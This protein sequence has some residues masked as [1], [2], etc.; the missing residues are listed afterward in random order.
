[1]PGPGPRRVG[2]VIRL[3][4]SADSGSP[5][6]DGGG[7]GGGVVLD[8]DGVDQLCALQA[9]V[10]IAAVVGVGRGGKSTLV[11]A[12]AIVAAVE[13]SA[14]AGMHVASDE[15][16]LGA[17]PR[18]MCEVTDDVRSCTRGLWALPVACDDGG[19]LLLIDTEGLDR[20]GVEHEAAGASGA[21]IQMVAL[22]YA[23]SGVVAINVRGAP[24]HSHV[25]QFASMFALCRAVSR[26]AHDRPS[27][28]VVVR[29]CDAEGI[30]GAKLVDRLLGRS[31]MRKL[32]AALRAE[33]DQLDGSFTGWRGC[34]VRSPTE[35]DREALAERRTQ[36]HW[37]AC[38]AR[39]RGVGDGESEAAGTEASSSTG[40]AG[41][42]AGADDDAPPAFWRMLVR[43][44]RTTMQTALATPARAGALQLAGSELAATVRRVWRAIVDFTRAHGL[45]GAPADGAGGAV[46]SVA[47][48]YELLH[49]SRAQEILS[50]MRVVPR[51][52]DAMRTACDLVSTATMPPTSAAAFAARSASEVSA[53][54][55]AVTEA[56]AAEAAYVRGE[57]VRAC[58]CAGV[59]GAAA[60]HAW[61]HNVQWRVDADARTSADFFARLHARKVQSEADEEAA[62]VFRGLAAAKR[63][64]AIASERAARLTEHA[65]NAS[66]AAEQQ[67][68]RAARGD[69]RY[70]FYDPSADAQQAEVRRIADEY[71]AR[72]TSAVGA[73]LDARAR[74]DVERA[75]AGMRAVVCEYDW[76][77]GHAVCGSAML[78]AP[79]TR[80]VREAPLPARCRVG[81]VG[82]EA[83][84]AARVVRA[85]QVAA[86]CK[87]AGS[88]SG[89]GA[90]AGAGG[91]GTVCDGIVL[92]LLPGMGGGALDAG[93]GLEVARAAGLRDRKAAG[94]S[95]DADVCRGMIFVVP[96]VDALKLLQASA[97]D[98]RRGLL[99]AALRPLQELM[100]RRFD[101]GGVVA[102]TGIEGLGD[103]RDD[104]LL[105][106]LS[107]VY[108]CRRDRVFGVRNAALCDAEAGRL[109][110]ADALVLLSMLVAAVAHAEG[111][112][113]AEVERVWRHARA[114]ARA[115]RRAE[116]AGHAESYAASVQPQA[117]DWSDGDS[118]AD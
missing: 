27:A 25:Q 72:V 102:L 63:D 80:A 73:C 30:T 2:S 19:T 105:G 81:V 55:R 34:V 51:V 113:S 69:V 43:A 79:G 112:M 100:Q 36:V 38:A 15:A 58:D 90:G 94:G 85:V 52:H 3:L 6:A 8:D 7:G 76:R 89:S 95:S 115:A 103:M 101:M 82:M 18:A 21:L 87:S 46:L 98:S 111:V 74:H 40:N 110:D 33:C 78:G 32:D 93:R 13:A 22:V 56:A 35:R 49:R 20:A 109:E 65:Q 53:L 17:L 4:R 10:R 50:G 108:A 70:E 23:I 54:P 48:L 11:N 75:V 29:D 99:A 24:D 91:G 106:V 45:A 92:T 60:R 5:D 77:H 118:D 31:G 64:E 26:G 42:G 9:P 83:D 57:F 84:S 114:R 104:A 12:C 62:R 59:D 88:G 37:L 41:A 117:E 39:M 47:P 14:A 97:D 116:A 61:E 86:A 68:Q 71:A 96:C 107:E 1:M 44:S 28:V 16:V 67:R 66:D